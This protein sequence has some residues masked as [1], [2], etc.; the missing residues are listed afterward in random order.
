MNYKPAPRT[1]FFGGS[2]SE[3]RC[4]APRSA[5]PRRRDCRAKPC[6]CRAA[7]A[8]DAAGPQ[9]SRAR[10]LAHCGHAAPP[11]VFTPARPSASV[12]LGKHGHTGGLDLEKA[13][14]V[15]HT[16]FSISSSL[17]SA[18][19]LLIFSQLCFSWFTTLNH[20]INQQRGCE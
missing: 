7:G 8:P 18:A 9:P 1:P 2:V 10:G 13:R 19:C 15:R 11:K 3:R 12:L 17:R 5:R 6:P 14:G 16:T 20:L 4:A